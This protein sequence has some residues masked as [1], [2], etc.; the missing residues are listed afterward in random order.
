MEPMKTQELPSHIGGYQHL[1]PDVVVR[2]DDILVEDGRPVEYVGFAVGESL[3]GDMESFACCRV[4]RKMP[5]AH[6]HDPL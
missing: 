5:V 2:P 4:Y 6:Q 3:A 1:E